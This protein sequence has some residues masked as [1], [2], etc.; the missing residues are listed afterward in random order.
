M[1]FFL[2][3]SLFRAGS[4]FPS[5]RGY[6]S[7]SISG[8]GHGS[9]KGENGMK[10]IRCLLVAAV[11]AVMLC[12]GAAAAEEKLPAYVYTGTDSV[13]AAAAA[14]I[15]E[16]R[17]AEGYGGMEEGAVTIPAPVILKTEETEDGGLL[18]YGNFWL[19]NYVRQDGILVCVSGG[20]YPG[21]MSMV[22]D[23]NG[24]KAVSLE[25]AGDGENYA[26]DIARFCS[27]D[28]DL[29]NAYYSAGDGQG[30]KVVSIRTRFVADYVKANALPVAAYQDP[31]WD[32]VYLFAAGTITG[33][34]EEDGSYLI[35]VPVRAGEP[36]EWKAGE[37][38]EGAAVKL[39][40][41]G[42]EGDAFR[43][44][45]EAAHDGEE[46]VVLRH[47]QGI[48]CDQMMEFCLKVSGGKITEVTGGSMTPG[49]SGD[50]LNQYLSGNW[51]EKDTQ[52]TR[53]RIARNPDRGWDAEII[54]PMTHEAYVFTATVYSDCEQ[55]ALLFDD[56]VR[57]NLT[58]EE[59]ENPQELGT[60]AETGI[61]GRIVITEDGQGGIALI[62]YS[63]MKEEP[64]VFVSEGL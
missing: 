39:A 20:E 53:M 62:W 14:W 34:L 61:S 59:Y 38:E 55:N 7:V 19:L 50:E 28:K 17:M 56:G 21:V 47:Y 22:K 32:P 26:K 29:E 64:V 35:N 45:Y 1:L 15:T 41:A 58:A 18:V 11:L 5:I 3:Y 57:Y 33:S 9:V 23:G 30:E 40:S 60:P 16:S 51:A 46:T 8:S 12:A 44:R 54:S 43:A 37:P 6:E 36:G 10:N 63:G 4:F 31:Y 13:E 2:P 48:A 42:M 25:T 52:F 24:W 27:G 49:M